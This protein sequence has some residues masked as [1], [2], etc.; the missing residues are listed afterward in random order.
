MYGWGE[1]SKCQAE[2]GYSSQRRTRTVKIQAANGGSPCPCTEEYRPCFNGPCCTECTLTPWNEWESC[3]ATCGGGVQHRRRFVNASTPNC[4]EMECVKQGLLETRSCNTVPCPPACTMDEWSGWSTCSAE[5][6]QG[7]Q[8][9]TRLI[10]DFGVGGCDWSFEE[11]PCN[12]GECPIP[13]TYT[14]W[15][16]WTPCGATCVPANAAPSAAYKQYRARHRIS[17]PGD[18]SCPPFENEDKNCEPYPLPC[19]VLCQV[20]EWSNWTDCSS[21]WGWGEQ[22]R[23]RTVIQTPTGENLCP[24]LYQI[25]RCYREPPTNDCTFSEW[26][27]WG[28]CSATCRTT[29]GTAPLKRRQRVLLTAPGTVTNPDGSVTLDQSGCEQFGNLAETLDCTE[30]PF[31][32]VDCVMTRWSSWSECVA[33]GVRHRTRRVHSPP[34]FGG[35]PCPVCVKETDRCNVQGNQVLPVG[36]CEVGPCLQ[37]VEREYAE[38]LRQQNEVTFA[39]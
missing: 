30:L 26:G 31:C 23:S 22:T 9:R 28:E 2:C 19:D 35:A 13:C 29:D 6:G 25:K 27:D 4:P 5:C 11:R 1:W 10:A 34:A 16:D 12:N 3:S 7:F 24:Q 18:T 21:Q 14:E 33:P 15:S 20:S 8:S 17:G 39:V 38:K 36:E 32:P 37:E